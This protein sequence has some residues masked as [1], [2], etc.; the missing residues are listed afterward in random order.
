LSLHPN[1]LQD[2]K[3]PIFWFSGAYPPTPGLRRAKK[4]KRGG[5][6]VKG[7]RAAGQAAGYAVAGLAAAAVLT[8]LVRPVCSPSNL[9]GERDLLHVENLVLWVGGF[10]I[11]HGN[12]ASPL[13]WRAVLMDS[14]AALAWRWHA[15][16]PPLFF[17]AHYCQAGFTGQGATDCVTKA[18]HRSTTTRTYENER[19][20]TLRVS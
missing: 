6:Q 15:P 3:R 5:G 4:G 16:L 19:S 17:N 18:K 12:G 2:P 20:A 10:K 13:F 11:R 7:L 14:A 8:A 1:Q 9:Q